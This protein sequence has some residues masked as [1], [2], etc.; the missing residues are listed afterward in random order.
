[1]AW[2]IFSEKK[3]SLDISVA[4]LVLVFGPT[5]QTKNISIR[6]H[7]IGIISGLIGAVVWGFINKDK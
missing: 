5:L 7:V 3:V 4:M 2:E 6:D 1:M